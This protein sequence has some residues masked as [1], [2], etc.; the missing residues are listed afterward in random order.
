MGRLS[1][2]FVVGFLLFSALFPNFPRISP[3]FL[4]NFA[5][6]HRN[7]S[8]IPSSRGSG[9]GQRGWHITVRY[10][11][12]FRR[13]PL[14][15]APV[16]PEEGQKPSGVIFVYVRCFCYMILACFL[17]AVWSR[18]EAPP[19]PSAGAS[20]FPPGPSTS[21]PSSELSGPQNPHQS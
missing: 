13:R 1:Y 2:V 14:A 7:S 11:R 20:R 6:A 15:I 5:R 18:L 10:R 3:E 12:R 21:V 8:T 9:S 4:R 19:G 16:S 17:E